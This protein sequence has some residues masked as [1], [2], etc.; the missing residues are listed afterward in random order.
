MSVSTARSAACSFSGGARVWVG[1]ATCGVGTKR[2][3][4]AC[5]C[6]CECVN[7]SWPRCFGCFVL[8]RLT[9]QIL[10]E[11][12]TN[13]SHAEPEQRNFRVLERTRLESA[14]SPC[15]MSEAMLLNCP[16]GPVQGDVARD[17]LDSNAPPA[18][19]GII[20]SGPARQA[21][22]GTAVTPP[23]AARPAPRRPL[24]APRTCRQRRSARAPPRAP[25]PP[26]PSRSPCSTSAPPTHRCA[27]AP[28]TAAPRC[29]GSRRP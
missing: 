18:R 16:G 26:C 1:N 4:A 12:V 22:C 10:P 3:A 20:P 11:V 27:P 7:T 23:A 19:C 8:P 17:L 25:S 13:T 14:T 9:R 21:L 2:H 28:G 24:A 15:R 5:L 29:T 6:F